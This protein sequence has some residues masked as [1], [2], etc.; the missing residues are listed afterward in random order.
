MQHAIRLC[1]LSTLCA[2]AFGQAVTA[3]AR[4]RID[5]KMETVRKINGRWWSEDNRQLKPAKND[6]Y[7]WYIG[8]RKDKGWDFHHHRPVDLS[9]AEQLHLLMNPTQVRQLLGQPNEDTGRDELG[10][11]MWMYYAANGTSLLVRFTKNELSD[12]Q[13]Q[14]DAWGTQ[15]LPVQSVANDMQGRSPFQVMA[16][17][18][19]Q[20]LA[21]ESYAKSHPP[22]APP[23][24]PSP[25]LQAAA[26]RASVRTV[27]VS[28]PPKPPKRRIA[29]DLADSVHPGMT[30]MDVVKTLGNPA[31]DF[32]ISGETELETLSYPL[33]PDGELT[34]RLEN[35][36]VS[37]IGR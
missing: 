15:P 2:A 7:T 28:A 25:E 17:R 35:G 10:S 23:E 32:K 3:T 11:M 27:K 30:R 4:V 21:P 34:I 31:S 19:W 13:Y 22:A 16:D 20:R 6:E 26:R 29:A 24:V 1:L 14:N 12:A 37:K 8:T 36:A 9:L 5:R 33:D 18:A